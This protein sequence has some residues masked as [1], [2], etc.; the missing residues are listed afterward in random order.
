MIFSFKHDLNQSN[1]ER[2]LEHYNK[3]IRLS[4]TMVLFLPQVR[5]DI[6]GQESAPWMVSIIGFSNLMGRMGLGLLCHFPNIKSGATY[7]VCNVVSGMAIAAV[8][9]FTDVPCKLDS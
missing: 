6:M 5:S 1:I 9:L 2:V 8:P 3:L 4:L 7:L